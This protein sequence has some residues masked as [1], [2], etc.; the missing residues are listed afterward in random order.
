MIELAKKA[1][2]AGGAFS[3]VAAD[4]IRFVGG[5]FFEP[6]AIPPAQDGDAY[7]MRYILHDW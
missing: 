7:F 2:G 3:S 1:Y 5:S 4:R 6:K